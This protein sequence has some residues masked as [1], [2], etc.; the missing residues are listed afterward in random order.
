MTAKM[1]FLRIVRRN[2][3]C[4]T[5]M[6][7]CW[8]AIAAFAVYLV[9]RC[10]M[11]PGCSGE[12]GI[13]LLPLGFPWILALLQTGAPAAVFVVSVFLNTLIVGAIA[14]WLAKRLRLVKPE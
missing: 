8:I 10:R 7:A 9:D 6:A 2:A 3:I 14:Q 5:T 11:N 1:N 4:L 13:Y 12:S